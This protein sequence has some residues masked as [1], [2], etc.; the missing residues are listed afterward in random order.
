MSHKVQVLTLLEENRAVYLSGQH[1]AD[2][3]GISRNAVWKIIRSLKSEGYAIEA[4]TN[5]GYRISLAPD[6]L[7]VDAIRSELHE[8][9]RDIPIEVYDTIDSTNNLAK[10]R[11][12]DQS[13]Y[14]LVA[15]NE[16]TAGRGRRGR[17]FVSPRGN[18]IYTSLV[19][20]PAFP[21]QDAYFATLIAVVAV[22]RVLTRLTEETID[23]KWVNDLYIREKKVCGILTE[24]VSDV[25]MRIEHIV[26]GI[27]INL[28]ADME[29]YPEEV[30]SIA[31][32]LSVEGVARNEIIAQIVNEMLPM[33]EEPDRS[34]VL[35][36][37]RA[38]QML[39]GKEICYEQNGVRK[40][41]VVCGVA[42]NGGLRVESDGKVSILMSGE[43]SVKP[44]KK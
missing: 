5:K 11:A 31:G 9:Y 32:S 34:E 1:I 10:K 33:M 3:L 25:E 18:G 28:N 13:G 8:N 23:I 17:T 12:E 39:H 41:G 38:H 40:T 37:Y 7:H 36:E 26:V 35:K 42:D 29:Q 6:I 4:K 27:G 19:F 30:S 16:Q 21:L 44:V 20:R 15:A 43:V 2:V 14:F 24:L 22:R